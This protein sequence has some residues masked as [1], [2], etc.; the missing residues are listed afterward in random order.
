ML[1]LSRN[2]PD[3]D[4][5][6]TIGAYAAGRGR[7]VEY[8]IALAF[9][10][11]LGL[12]FPR[13]GLGAGVAIALVATI[14]RLHDFGQTGWWSALV[15]AIVAPMAGAM[16]LAPVLGTLLFAG[17][18]VGVVVFAAFVG[19]MPS[20]TGPNRFGA[21][22]PSLFSRKPADGAEETLD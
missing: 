19:L 2:R 20:D 14:R 15:V 9:A 4:S 10:M 8:W 6:R 3:S 12:L 22:P 5:R 16:V 11:L 17:V 18:A 7:R 1:S 21:E 13:F